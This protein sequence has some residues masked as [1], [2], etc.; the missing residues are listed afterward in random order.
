MVNVLTTPNLPI[1]NYS[2]LTEIRKRF[3]LLLCNKLCNK[4]LGNVKEIRTY[5]I[6]CSTSV[7]G[8]RNYIMRSE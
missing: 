5:D 4:A 6:E 1:H 8:G 3:N 2:E 7:T